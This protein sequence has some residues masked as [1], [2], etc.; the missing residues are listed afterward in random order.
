MINPAHFV[1]P[2]LLKYDAA[3]R[4]ARQELTQNQCMTKPHGH[5]NP[6]GVAAVAHTHGPW[7]GLGLGSTA[8]AGPS[9]AGRRAACT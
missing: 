4:L 1:G 2:Q 9:R 3:W 8:V 5:L 6:T 7:P